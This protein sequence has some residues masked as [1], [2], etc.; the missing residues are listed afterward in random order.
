[1]EI[2]IELGLSRELGSLLRQLILGEEETADEPTGEDTGACIDRKTEEREKPEEPEPQTPAEP[3]PETKPE[4]QPMDETEPEQAIPEP[5]IP[6]TIPPTKEEMKTLMD[7][8][9]SKFAG[10][11]WQDSKEARQVRITKDC[12][13]CFKQIA[14]HLGAERPTALE[15]EER[16]RFIEELDRLFLNVNLDRVE[17]NAF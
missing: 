6:E 5:E 15:G 11:D 8:T 17:W 16:I 4:P 12:T 13:K 9:I 3:E 7:I 2:K 10:N 14:Q 1:M